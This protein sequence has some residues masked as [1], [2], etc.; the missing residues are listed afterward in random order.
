MIKSLK[1]SYVKQ[2]NNWTKMNKYIKENQKQN[3]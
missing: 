2:T 3:K 1:E